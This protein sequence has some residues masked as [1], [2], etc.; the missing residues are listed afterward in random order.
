M[1]VL[2]CLQ[3]SSPLLL[4][5]M[6]SLLHRIASHRIASVRPLLP[7]YYMM[8]ET[9]A[10]RCPKCYFLFTPYAHN[11]RTSRGTVRDRGDAAGLAAEVHFSSCGALIQGSYY[12]QCAPYIPD[13]QGRV[14]RQGREGSV[15]R[16]GFKRGQ[17]E[18]V[19]R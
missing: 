10:R 3:P 4:L 17:T 15:G 19:V 9:A 2:F 7:P 13:G 18:S 6:C 5:F 14:V 1:D 12:I 8:E 11:S 16:V